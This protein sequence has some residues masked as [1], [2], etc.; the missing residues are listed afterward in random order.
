MEKEFVGK[1]VEILVAIA[2]SV[3]DAGISPVAFRG[4]LLESDNQFIKLDARQ[5][6]VSVASRFGALF[7]KD[8]ECVVLLKKDYIIYIKII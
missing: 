3:V 5:S 6:E 7:S 4:I 8:E 2:G 1:E